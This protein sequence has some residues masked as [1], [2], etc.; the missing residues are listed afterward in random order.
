MARSGRQCGHQRQSSC[1]LPGFLLNVCQDAREGDI[2]AL[3]N[4]RQLDKL[5]A[6]EQQLARKRSKRETSGAKLHGPSWA[7]MYFLAACSML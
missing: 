1:G 6:P 5:G 4:V 7:L 3:D 2:H